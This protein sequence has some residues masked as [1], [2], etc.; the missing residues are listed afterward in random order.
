MPTPLKLYEEL[1]Y[2]ISTNLTKRLDVIDNNFIYRAS[3]NAQNKEVVVDGVFETC[4][5]RQD[6][7]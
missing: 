3:I 2:I 1:T 4:P 7:L 5:M 6:D